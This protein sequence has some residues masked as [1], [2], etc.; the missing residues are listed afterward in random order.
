M[1]MV[2]SELKISSG[3]SFIIPGL[4]VFHALFIYIVQILFTT[5]AIAKLG[6]LKLSKLYDTVPTRVD[7]WVHIGYG[8]IVVIVGAAGL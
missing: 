7:V 3:L 8:I 6:P 4:C 5:K 2:W 1:C